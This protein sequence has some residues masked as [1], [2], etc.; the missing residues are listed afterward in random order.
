MKCAHVCNVIGSLLNI[1]WRSVSN[2]RSESHHTKHCTTRMETCINTVAPTHPVCKL[3]R[4]R[5]TDAESLP[6]QL[7]FTVGIAVCRA[8]PPRRMKIAQ[9]F[10]GG[11]TERNISYISKNDTILWDPQICMGVLW[12]PAK[13]CDLCD[14]DGGWGGRNSWYFFSEG[15]TSLWNRQGL[16]PESSTIS[17]GEILHL[18]IFMCLL[19]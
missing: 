19:G 3:Q 15:C 13:V 17:C 16:S 1:G 6:A 7:K 12:W 14:R 5:L 2:W 11:R 10:A 8:C 4:M 18:N 9:C